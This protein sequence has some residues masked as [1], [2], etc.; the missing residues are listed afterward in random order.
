MFQHRHLRLL[1]VLLSAVV[2]V[3]SVVPSKAQDDDAYAKYKDKCKDACRAQYG[4][5]ANMP[6]S[7]QDAKVACFKNSA[8]C[9][10]ACDRR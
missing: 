4:N 6:M 2:F 7:D 10:N 3:L 5:C 9:I 8:A 1:I